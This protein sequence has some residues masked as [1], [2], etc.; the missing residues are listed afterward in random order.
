MAVTFKISEGPPTIVSNMSVQQT[1]PILDRSGD[2]AT[3]RARSQVSAQSDPA[4][5]GLGLSSAESLGTG[6]TPTLRVDT[7][8]VDR[9]DAR[10]TAVVHR[11]QPRYG[12]AT[13]EDIIVEGNEGL[14]AAP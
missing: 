8:I 12:R 4:R 2:R 1:Q 10:K 14:S 13:V 9:L 6:A 7:S 11:S 5:L 3:A